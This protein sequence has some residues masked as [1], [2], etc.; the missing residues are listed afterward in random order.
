MGKRNRAES[1]DELSG[2]P[3][4]ESL[5][6]LKSTDYKTLMDIREKNSDFRKFLE[7]QEG[8]FRNIFPRGIDIRNL[9][10]RKEFD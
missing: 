5:E 3:D 2:R 6:K 8:M 4:L 7:K 9:E 1:S 10:I